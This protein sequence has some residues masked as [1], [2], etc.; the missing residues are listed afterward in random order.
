MQLRPDGFPDDDEAL[1]PALPSRRCPRSPCRGL[2]TS[3]TRSNRE[4]DSAPPHFQPSLATGGFPH[5]NLSLLSLVVDLLRPPFAV[6]RHFRR[7]GE[8]F[9]NLAILLIKMLIFLNDLMLLE[10]F[11]LKLV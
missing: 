11:G 9:S 6:N 5:H 8:S 3:H 1:P 4:G 10:N 7:V 2:E